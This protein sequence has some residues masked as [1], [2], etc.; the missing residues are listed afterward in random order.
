LTPTLD[1][2]NCVNNDA[3][4]AANSYTISGYENMA[5]NSILAFDVYATNPAAAV[6]APSFKITAFIDAART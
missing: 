5:A 3:G 2:F 4:A 1:Y 6:A